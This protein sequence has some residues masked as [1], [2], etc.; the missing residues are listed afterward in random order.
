MI[1]L[2]V[3][4][5]F[6]YNDLLLQVVAPQDHPPP[7]QPLELLPPGRCALGWK[8][9]CRWWSRH[10]HQDTAIVLLALCFCVVVV[11][12]QG[13]CVKQCQ[14]RISQDCSI[15]T[16]S[17]LDHSLFCTLPIIG[18]SKNSFWFKVVINLLLAKVR[19]MISVAGWSNVRLCIL[20]VVVVV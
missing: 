13:G 1:I 17:V 8:T 2:H 14:K 5:I 20:P 4:A 10:W 6:Y 19:T 12:F 11:E 18:S 3:C 16:S 7:F 15:E 9:S